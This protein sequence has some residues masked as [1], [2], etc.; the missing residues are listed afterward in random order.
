MDCHPGRYASQPQ[1]E[2]LF[3]QFPVEPY[4][5][6]HVGPFPEDTIEQAFWRFH[7][8]NPQVYRELVVLA[9]RARSRGVDRLGIGMLFEVL[10]WRHTLRTGGDEFKLN[11]NYRSY[12]S[13][14]IMLTEA[15]LTDVF[16]T[17]RLHAA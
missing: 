16:E 1:A 12:Y 17:R 15:D 8:E 2:S 4:P 10:R 3:D 11:N 9:R 13:R 14:L 6:G 7:T 5:V